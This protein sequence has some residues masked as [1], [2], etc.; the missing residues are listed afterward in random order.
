MRQEHLT[1]SFDSSILC[2][3]F[4]YPPLFYSLIFD[5]LFGR[6]SNQRKRYKHREINSFSLLLLSYPFGHSF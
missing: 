5:G 1:V 2:I 6:S 3:L 4:N